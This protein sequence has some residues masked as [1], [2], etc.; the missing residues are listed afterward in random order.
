MKLDFPFCFR[1]RPSLEKQ[2]SETFGK[3]IIFTH[4]RW[5]C[6]VISSDGMRTR[7]QICIWLQRES[8]PLPPHSWATPEF[9]QNIKYFQCDIFWLNYSHILIPLS[10]TSINQILEHM[11]KWKIMHAGIFWLMFSLFPFCLSLFICII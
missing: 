1:Y 11:L 9:T 5:V 7:T 6:Q 8:S 3:T 10:S 4:R 2:S